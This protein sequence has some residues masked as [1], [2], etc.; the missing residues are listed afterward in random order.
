MRRTKQEVNADQ[1]LMDW[2]DEGTEGTVDASS[3]LPDIVPEKKKGFKKAPKKEK[4][5]APKKGNKKAKGKKEQI[6]VNTVPYTKVYPASDIIQEGNMYSVAYRVSAPNTEASIA[7]QLSE[8]KEALLNLV[9]GFSDKISF[10]FFAFNQE[11]DKQAYLNNARVEVD[12]EFTDVKKKYN[13]LIETYAE[14]GSNFVDKSRYFILRTEKEDI[15]AAV[16]CLSSIEDRIKELFYEINEITV[17]KISVKDRLLLMYNLY[18]PGENQFGA[19]VKADFDSID[20]EEVKK[21]KNLTTKHLIAPRTYKENKNYIELNE[22]MYVRT[23]FINNIPSVMSENLVSDLRNVSSTMVYSVIYEPL[24]SEYGYKTVVKRIKDNTIVDTKKDTSS[25]SAR[26]SGKI[27]KK[28]KMIKSNEQT[29]F[30]QAALDMI[31][32]AKDRG[33]KIYLTAITIALY[34][35]DLEKLEQDSER[36]YDSANKFQFQIKPLDFQQLN[37]LRSILPLANTHIDVFRCLTAENASTLFPLDLSEAIKEDGT[38]YGLNTINDNIILLNRKNNYHVSGMITG[39]KHSGKTYAVKREVVNEL[40]SN[41]DCIFVITNKPE[42][43]ERLE[44]EFDAS[45]FESAAYDLFT[46]PDEYGITKEK[47]ELKA[48]FLAALFATNLYK[49][50]VFANDEERMQA[51][52]ELGQ[53][54][55]TLLQRQKEGVPFNPEEYPR[56]FDAITGYGKNPMSMTFMTGG[57]ETPNVS[58]LNI[59]YAPNPS[60]MAIAIDYVWN[61]QIELMRKDIHSW[62]FIDCVDSIIETNEG[63]KWIA[64]LIELSNSLFNPLTIVINNSAFLTGDNNVYGQK[65]MQK[66]LANCGYVKLLNEGP[67]ERKFYSEN[68]N[69][70]LAIQ[71]YISNVDIG[72]GL[73][74]TPSG[75]IPFDDYFHDEADTFYEIFKNA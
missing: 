37:G 32:S 14:V 50:S 68:L 69:I 67:V 63:A 34:A 70:P 66:I 28:E 44:A 51:E 42:E 30:E 22:N 7:T 25:I 49:H 45:V 13:K 71:P 4:V 62:V 10:Q 11:S 64:D 16:Q 57:E 39:V 29:Y 12:D 5:A 24:S 47:A 74:I 21:A 41:D 6:R 52:D 53:E 46:A 2:F 73:I 20:F 8:M 36:L 18:N 56:I 15:D 38:F 59:V 27:I 26:K 9:N 58:G 55:A 60:D 65:A 75:C 23:F 35:S 54:C 43:Y 31:E 3:D 19:R 61:M 17:E 33:E 48:E 40:I 1:E 72:C